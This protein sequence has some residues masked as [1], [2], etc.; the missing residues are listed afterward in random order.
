MT[1][2]APTKNNHQR[3]KTAGVWETVQK[4]FSNWTGSKIENL[5][6][7]KDSFPGN[8]Q[9]GNQAIGCV[10]SS[11]ALKDIEFNDLETYKF[12]LIGEF[13]RFVKSLDLKN[14]LKKTDYKRRRCT[15]EG[16]QMM[17]ELMTEAE[18]I[19]YLRI[20][21]I[22]T[23]KDYANVIYNLKRMRNLPRVHICN[24]P[25]YPKQAIDKWLQENVLFSE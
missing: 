14:S 15:G 3:F 5:K 21:E 13:T 24:K 9:L 17:P 22:S 25:L 20:P 18:L 6:F 2:K 16:L 1:D 7:R 8:E 19:E 10:S 12:H 4:E 11:I 23:A